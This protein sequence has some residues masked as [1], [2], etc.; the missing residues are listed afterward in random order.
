MARSLACV[1]RTRRYRSQCLRLWP[2]HGRAWRALRRRAAR[3]HR[4]AGLRWRNRAPSDPAR[5]LRRRCAVRDAVLCAQ[6]CRG[7]RRHGRGSAIIAAADRRVR[8][9]TLERCGPAR[10]R[11]ALR[12]QGARLYGLSEFSDRA[13]PANATSRKPGCMA[14]KIIS[15]SRSSIPRHCTAADRRNRRVGDHHLDQS[16]AA[17]D[18]LSHARH[19][20][21]R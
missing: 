8:G 10:D 13:S 7:R 11:A 1:G 4:R 2:V 14:G 9:G 6:H 18:P 21:T 16:S 12:D 19:F 3:L 17:D 5:G 20:P 15:C